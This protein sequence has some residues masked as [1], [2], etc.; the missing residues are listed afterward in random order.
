MTMI[1]GDRVKWGRPCCIFGCAFLSAL[2]TLHDDDASHYLGINYLASCCDLGVMLPAPL[3][4]LQCI[5]TVSMLHTLVLKAPN[6][7]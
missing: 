1:Y 7:A 6:V 4:F 2:H 5:L 3:Q